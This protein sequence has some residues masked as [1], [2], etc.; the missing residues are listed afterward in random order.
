MITSSLIVLRTSLLCF[1]QYSN[2]NHDGK[3]HPTRRQDREASF[4]SDLTARK[5]LHELREAL[6]NAIYA[7]LET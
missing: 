4:G 3:Q 7:R 5:H 6:I 2:S 1:E